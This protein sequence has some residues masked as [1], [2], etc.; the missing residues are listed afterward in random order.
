MA[1]IFYSMAGEGRGHAVR[2]RVL[3]DALRRDH[4]IVLFAPGDAYD[5]LAPIYGSTDVRVHRIPGLRF[6]YSDGRLNFLRTTRAAAEY[7]WNLPRLLARLER[8]MRHERPDLVITD[9]EP[10]LPRAAQ[11]CGIPFISLNHQHL[12]VANDLSDLPPP[13]RHSATFM[14]LIVRAYYS[15]QQETIVSSFYFPPLKPLYRHVQ[16]IGVLLR[17]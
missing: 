7:L 17:P 1:R 4:E 5:L 15:G 2:V 11:R 16:Q 3:V 6:C 14:G 12:L 13:L 8:L 10:S 9:F